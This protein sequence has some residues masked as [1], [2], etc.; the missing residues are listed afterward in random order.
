M[1]RLMM[2]SE[3][4]RQL[5]QA[6]ATAGI[7]PGALKMAMYL[8]ADTPRSMSE[9]AQRFSCDASYVTS[10][11]DGLEQQ[12]LAERRAHPSDRRVRTVSL[13]EHGVRVLADV[14]AVLSAP[15]A[16]LDVLD[17]DEQ[18]VLRDL[19]ARVADAA[20]NA[21]PAVHKV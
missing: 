9:L 4:H 3:A 13:T 20:E 15:P 10:I 12:G 18:V 7:T 17:E 16:A 19:L 8:S 1:R 14:S 11:V 21:S 5:L 2:S 6:C